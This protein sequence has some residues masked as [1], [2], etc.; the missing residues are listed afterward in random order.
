MNQSL[1]NCASSC[2]RGRSQQGSY[3][4]RP[5]APVAVSFLLQ[6]SQGLRTIV[7]KRPSDGEA[8][9]LQSEAEE[10]LLDYRNARITLEKVL[11]LQ[12]SDDK[13]D[14]KRLA[15]LREYEAWWSGLRLTPDQQAQLGPPFGDNTADGCV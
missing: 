13:R 15:L 3:R 9:R 4:G 1:P 8:W 11:A 12:P 7:Q 2:G 6:A 5:P 10:A 14:L